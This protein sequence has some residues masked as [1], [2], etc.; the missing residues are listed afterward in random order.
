MSLCR[1]VFRIMRRW[2]GWWRTSVF[3]PAKRRWFYLPVVLSAI[4]LAAC[5]GLNLGGNVSPTSTAASTNVPLSTLHWCGKPLMSFRDLAAAA[6]AT[7]GATPNSTTTAQ[8]TP[9]STTAVQ[10]TASSTPSAKTNSLGPANG[11]PTTI[12]DW[13]LVKANLGFTIFLPAT[14]PAGSCL[15][16]AS[17]TL[18][19]PILGSNFTIIYLLPDNSSI[20]LS[21]APQRSQNT[22]FQCSTSPTTGPSGSTQKGGTPKPTESVAQA[23]VQLCSGVRDKT[24]IVFSARGTSQTLQ[25]FFHNLQSGVDWMPTS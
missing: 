10:A 18:R 8:A 9:N 6:N 2:E 1:A 7:P 12:T 11:T 23:P 17:G 22:A 20:S 24:N 16:S 21:Q 4:L 14:L 25:V 3:L 19:D 5:S 15:L 13:S